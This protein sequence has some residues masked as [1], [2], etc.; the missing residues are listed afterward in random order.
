VV[1]GLLS[2][3][4]LIVSARAL[5]PGLFGEVSVVWSL[6][7]AIGT[8]VFGPVEQETTQ[9]V[10]AGHRGAVREGMKSAGAVLV[11]V[12]GV[13]ALL[14]PLA[15]PGLFGGDGLPWLVLA[16]FAVSS[17]FLS[18][19]R[20]TLAARSRFGWYGAVL[21][22]ES[23]CRAGGALAL[24]A[25][26]SWS[27]AAYEALLPISTGLAAAVA[28]V[29][30]RRTAVPEPPLVDTTPKPPTSAATH[31]Q[32][33]LL[34]LAT[35]LAQLLINLPPVVVK[36]TGQPELAGQT[37]ALLAIARVPVFLAPALTA[38]ML[39]MLVRI[40]LGGRAQALLRTVG[41]LVGGVVVTGIVAAVVGLL[42]GRP[43]I[44]VL[45]G[46]DYVLPSIYLAALTLASF[47]FLAALV[48]TAALVAVRRNGWSLVSWSAGLA[49]SALV[50]LAIVPV[51]WDVV[52]GLAV[53][54]S[55]ALV[56]AASAL[57]ATARR[58]S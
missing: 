51:P 2:Y 19:L 6:A 3:V 46:R 57:V 34:V 39:P 30:V 29:G 9:R 24:S 35:V 1:A 26:P 23:A 50:V 53:G 25:W 36:A 44:G 32:L 11:V 41:S 27:P 49:V 38:P 20:G 56:L 28:F 40:H 37:L 7:V 55:A 31:G 16:A 45:F 17:A 8:G 4:Y 5:G 58:G 22:V 12:L 47:L 14:A 54:T 42:V 10:A 48:V 52:V 21:L 18:P 33:T 43:V 13:M 15:L